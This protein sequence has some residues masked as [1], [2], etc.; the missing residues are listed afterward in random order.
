MRRCV[1]VMIACLGLAVHS[2]CGDDDSDSNDGAAQD[3]GVA[4]DVGQGDPIEVSTSRPRI[5]FFSAGASNL[6]LRAYNDGV[7]EEAERRGFEVTT[8]DSQFDAARQLDQVQNGL[9]QDRFDA[10]LVVALDGNLMCPVLTR[11]APAAGIPVV[12]SLTPICDRGLRPE[13]PEQWAPGTVAHVQNDSTVTEAEAWLD[14]IAERRTGRHTAAILSGPPL[15]TVSLAIKQAVEQAQEAHPDLDFR[16]I[17][18]T[19]F[20]TPDGLAKTQT[21]LQAHPEVDT[22]ISIYSDLT[23]GAIRA[24]KA[25]GR[26]A[27]VQIF[28]QAGSEQSIAAVRAGDLEMT[29]AHT[30]H[31]NGVAAVTAVADAFAGR[32]VERY[33][34]VYPEGASSGNPL[35]IDA[36]NA[37]EFEPQ[38]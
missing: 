14:A 36:E 7:A 3:G 10:F 29:T 21:L 24:V 9:Q 32:E 19:D 13:G 31:S 16:Y 27:E 35:V 26:E 20:T 11:Q 6:Y 34:G 22:V 33:I 28:D 2:G 37:D 17:I 12:T 18:D 5:A 8:F 4:I 30:P 25:A 15:L 38:Y 1:L 23:V